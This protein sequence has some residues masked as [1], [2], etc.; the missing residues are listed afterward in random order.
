[1]LKIINFF[2]KKEDCQTDALLEYWIESGKWAKWRNI[3]K[4][5]PFHIIVKGEEYSMYL[6]PF[7]GMVLKDFD[8][9][10][11]FIL[12]VRL[13]DSINNSPEFLA[14]LVKA[15]HGYRFIYVIA[16]ELIKE[17]FSMLMNFNKYTP[18]QIRAAFDL[19]PLK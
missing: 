10:R 12:L 13:W 15:L 19:P 7:E 9:V 1:M 6:E 14:D 17:L 4:K 11:D 5:E 2:K 3:C 8:G 16:E 18:D